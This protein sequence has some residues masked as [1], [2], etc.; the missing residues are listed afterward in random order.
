MTI[1]LLGALILCFPH[2]AYADSNAVRIWEEGGSR[3][4]RSNG[5][6]DHP[7]GNFPNRGNPN[8]ISSQSYTF[9]VPLKPEINQ[10]P[11]SYGHDLF[12]VALNGIPFDPGTAEFWNSDPSSGWNYEALSG[13]INLGID[14]N[15][16]HVQPSGAYHYHGIPAGLLRRG[17]TEAGYS[18]R[19]GT[20][21]LTN[22]CTSSARRD[23]FREAGAL[24]QLVL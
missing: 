9:R 17:A 20:P 11:V 7:T 19:P 15:H 3:Y 18:P 16:A 14:Q 13:K 12:G 22:R 8:T 1:F 10:Q 5:I 21:T 6:P 24:H 2:W 4:I 23:R